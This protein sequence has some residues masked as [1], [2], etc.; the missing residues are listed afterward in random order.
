MFNCPENII[1][2]NLQVKFSRD[3][4]DFY[5]EIRSLKDGREL[6]FHGDDLFAN[7][8]ARLAKKFDNFGTVV[9][10]AR[11]LLENP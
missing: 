11:V 6:A 9:N 5:V 2:E 3:N 4:A 7:N 8:V 1:T 10:G